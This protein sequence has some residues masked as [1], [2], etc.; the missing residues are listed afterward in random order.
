[1]NA[2]LDQL[3]LLRDAYRGSVQPA[4]WGGQARRSAAREAAFFLPHLA[5]G[6]TVLDA[7]CGTGG[8]TRGLAKA[9]SAERSGRLIGV[10]AD[11]NAL[12]IA[13]NEGLAGIPG[14]EL[15]QADV[16][17]L[18]FADAS[19]DAVFCHGV[20]EHLRRP[21]DGLRELRRV[22]RPGGVIGVVDAE[23]DSRVV[24]PMA[25]TLEAAIALM[26]RLIA[27]DS[28]WTFPE[29][30]GSDTQI[31]RRLRELL[32][33]AGFV[34]VRVTIR[35]HCDGT[36]EATLAA[37]E[38]EARLL[39]VPALVEYVVGLG[40]ASRPELTEMAEAWRAW[41]HEPGAFRA[42]FSCEALAWT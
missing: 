16:Y 23:H 26:D 30:S 35:P 27:N 5:P 3:T 40:W 10:D 31:G 1:M 42:K 20:L 24:W 19:F 18:P 41:G 6:M 15:L 32:H 2:G 39:E 37:G 7:G 9:I 33:E 13:R 34:G 4:H 25:G 29:R 21:I 28:G 38:H 8:I 17:A 11:A 22:L 36:A 14:A 12:E